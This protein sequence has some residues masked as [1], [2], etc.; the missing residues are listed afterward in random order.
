[1][2]ETGLG[3]GGELVPDPVGFHPLGVPAG[4]EGDG[5]L[6]AGVIAPNA[7]DH[8]ADLLHREAHRLIAVPRAAARR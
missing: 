8:R 7:L 5:E 4:A 2:L 6:R 3:E 1:M